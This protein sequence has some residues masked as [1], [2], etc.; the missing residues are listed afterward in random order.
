MHFQLTSN[1][2]LEHLKHLP[3][4]KVAEDYETV[5]RYFARI[6]LWILA[7]PSKQS[8]SLCHPYNAFNYSICITIQLTSN[9][10][11]MFAPEAKRL[12]IQIIN[13]LVTATP[14]LRTVRCTIYGSILT[15]YP[16]EALLHIN[17]LKG[18]T[19]QTTYLFRL[20]RVGTSSTCVS[21]YL[22]FCREKK[23]F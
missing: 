17:V 9:F 3:L 15:V 10:A 22:R 1:P 4:Y 21:R 11:Q 8:L 6:T 18:H 5:A 19:L 13:P 2:L 7:P 23:Y 20:R 12:R 16:T 14:W